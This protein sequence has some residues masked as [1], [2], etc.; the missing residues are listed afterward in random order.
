MSRALSYRR[1]GWWC[2]RLL[3]GKFPFV[4]ELFGREDVAYRAVDVDASLYSALDA[5]A[6]AREVTI[7]GVVGRWRGA[8]D[9]REDGGVGQDLAAVDEAK[10]AVGVGL[11]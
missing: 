5:F 9:G 11:G 2:S 10:A 4:C 3:G 7:A 6:F 8:E 1:R